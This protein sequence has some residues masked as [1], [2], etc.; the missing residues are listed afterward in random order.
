MHN[1]LYPLN[2][3]SIFDDSMIKNVLSKFFDSKL[4]CFVK[5][6]H[7][8]RVFTV[9]KTSFSSDYKKNSIVADAIVTNVEDLVIGVNT[10]D[11]IAVFLADKEN[12][13]IGLA[14]AGCKGAALDV[15]KNTVDS[16]V[17][18]GANTRNICA[19]LS[20]SI[21]CFSYEVHSDFYNHMLSVDSN[22]QIYFKYRDNNMYFDLTGYVRK[23]L[24]MIGIKSIFDNNIDTYD[25]NLFASYRRFT[26]KL[27]KVRMSNLNLFML[28]KKL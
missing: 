17:K 23:K 13:V 16:M 11:C 26:A 18:I 1:I 9:N 7:K 25:D 24:E 5:Q 22:T 15:V 20:P 2:T 8:N 19:M 28:K 12:N 14:H 4:Y 6:E 21:R 3:S 27:D 10:A